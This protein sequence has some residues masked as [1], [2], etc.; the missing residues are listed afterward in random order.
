MCLVSL[1]TA[2]TLC[3]AADQG[4]LQ[5]PR[6]SQL[7]AELRNKGWIAYSAMSE[8]GDWDLFLV[9]PDGSGRRNIT[10]TPE[11]H[12]L[13]VRFSPNGR[14]ILFRRLPKATKFAHGNWGALGQLVVAN[15]DGTNAQ[16]LGGNGELPWASWSPDASQVAC[17]TK[18]GIEI[19]DLASRKIV[20]KMDRKGIYQQLFWS[21]D[22]RWLTGPANTYGESWTVVRMNVA[23]GEVNPVSKYQNCTADWFPDSKRLIYS[24]RPANQGDDGG[25]S[26]AS[27]Q[28][29][30]YGWTQLWMANGDGTARQLIYGED[31]RHIYGG[32][33]SPDSKYVLFT[34][35]S[36]DG[37]MVDAFMH[38]MRLRDAPSI[39]GKSPALR[40][41]HPHTKDGPVLPLTLGWEPHWTYGHIKGLK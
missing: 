24:S 26:Q 30:Q 40:R 21:P 9:R 38:V 12:E 17:L 19:W 37:G 8:Q 25:L 36:K 34:T 39:A 4:T 28:K 3:F 16:A 31:G 5:D 29:P 13:G 14:Q 18:A 2:A 1:V 7:A 11:Y 23:T 32:D 33:I 15:S 27:G 22:G 10:N 20:R 41:L 35:S 6:S